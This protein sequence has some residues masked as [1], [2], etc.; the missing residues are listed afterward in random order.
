MTKV[1]RSTT[2][3]RLRCGASTE[4]ARFFTLISLSGATA[5]IRLFHFR[6]VPAL[7][8]GC[9]STTSYQLSWPAQSG[10]EH[11]S[12]YRHCTYRKMSYTVT[13]IINFRHVHFNASSMIIQIHFSLWSSQRETLLSQPCTACIAKLKP[14]KFLPSLLSFHLGKTSTN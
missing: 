10:W 8:W 6:A 13:A 9:N 12:I 4:V 2:S 1:I 7:R 3:P 5:Q 14:P 11:Q